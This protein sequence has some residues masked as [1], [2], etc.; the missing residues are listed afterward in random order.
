MKD[1]VFFFDVDGTL[2]DANTHMVLE[3]TTKALNEL[4]KLGY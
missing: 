2:I 1:T 4:K 3:N